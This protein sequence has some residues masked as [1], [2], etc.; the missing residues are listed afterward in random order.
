M[1]DRGTRQPRQ[2]IDVQ[3]N[4]GLPTVYTLHLSDDR[5]LQVYVDPGRSGTHV[6]EFHA[7]FLGPDGNELPMTDFSAS[8]VEGTSAPVELTTRKLD[9][10]GHY[11]ADAQL[12][13]GT[14][15]FTVFATAA[16]GAQ[17]GATLDIP[18]P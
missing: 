7:T 6:N 11:V 9:D 5:A 4:K 13:S 18:V 12:T 17:L 14:P 2:R 10:I 15:R 8:M 1:P 3:R 16:D